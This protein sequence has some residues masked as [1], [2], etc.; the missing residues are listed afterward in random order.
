VQFT[1]DLLPA[2]ITG[3]SFLQN[4]KTAASSSGE[5]P[6]FANVLL[7]D[8][9]FFPKKKNAGDQAAHPP[10]VGG[11]PR[12]LAGGKLIGRAREGKRPPRGG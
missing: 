9:N 7:A 1:P 11:G 2:D 10:P 5:G 6:V 4:R 8:E 12:F 3:S